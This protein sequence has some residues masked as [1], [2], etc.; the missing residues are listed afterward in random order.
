MTDTYVVF[1]QAGHRS[2]L[3]N[4]NYRNQLVHV[5]VRRSAFFSFHRGRN[6]HT[7]NL[8]E[9][10]ACVPV[11]R[12]Q[13]LQSPHHVAWKRTM[14]FRSD[15]PGSKPGSPTLSPGATGKSFNSLSSVFSS[16]QWSECSPGR[17]VVRTKGDEGLQQLIRREM[18]CPS[19]APCLLES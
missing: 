18:S 1:P 7:E 5:L 4:M 14:A 9:G 11:S 8:Q 16:I 17:V 2:L 12:G 15:S 6:C 13:V 10:T 19:S 3:L